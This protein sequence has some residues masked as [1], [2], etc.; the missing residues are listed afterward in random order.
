MTVVNLEAEQAVASGYV[1]QQ[2]RMLGLA[3][4]R[5]VIDPVAYFTVFA[6]RDGSIEALR[7]QL[8]V[9]G[10][11]HLVNIQWRDHAFCELLSCATG[12]I[13]HPVFEV[14]DELDARQEISYQDAFLDYRF[15]LHLESVP[16]ETRELPSH[17]RPRCSHQVEASFPSLPGHPNALTIIGANCHK[18]SIEVSPRRIQRTPSVIMEIR[19]VHWYESEGI[20]AVSRSLIELHKEEL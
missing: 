16:P 18:N 3:L 10:A 1:D 5:R 14:P 6:Q 15:H 19:S 12:L 7:I 13:S 11:S 9:I 17:L 8:T 4:F 20:A 2:S